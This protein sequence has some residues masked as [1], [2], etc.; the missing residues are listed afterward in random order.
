[1]AS[2]P[3]EHP[4]VENPIALSEWLTRMMITISGEIERKQ[5]MEP[6]GELPVKLMDGMVRYFD[7]AYPDQNIMSPGPYV[8]AEGQWRPMIGPMYSAVLPIAPY[9]GM[10]IYFTIDIPAT[11][12]TAIGPYV[13]VETVWVPLT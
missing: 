11:E 6:T 8:V 3:Q 9:N 5:D 4:P 2:L 12:I 13:Y 10:A 1:M 7:I